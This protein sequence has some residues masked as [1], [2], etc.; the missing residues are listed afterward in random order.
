VTFVV[1]T[2]GYTALGQL[3]GG[4]P[5]VTVHFARPSG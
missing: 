1:Y 3:A 5:T 2:R 4:D